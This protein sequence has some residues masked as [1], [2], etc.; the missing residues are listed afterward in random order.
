MELAPAALRPYVGGSS[1][2]SALDLVLGY[3]GL[4]RVFGSG[5]PGRGGGASFSGTPGLFRLFNAEMGG[6]AAWL[7]PLSLV[8]LVTGLVARRRTPRDDLARA[9]YLMWGLW[10]VTHVLLFSFMSGTIHGYYTVVLAPAI[11]ALVGGGV[12]EL[13]RAR[14]R[15]PWAG[16]VLGAAV[17][18]SVA[19][20]WTLLDRTPDFFPGLGTAVFAVGVAV[21]AAL[22][23]PATVLPRRVSLVA[24]GLA[25]AV[26]LAGPAAYA[27]DTMATA[28]SGGAVSAGPAADDI[29]RG[30]GP[31]A[32]GFRAPGSRQPPPGDAPGFASPGGASVPSFWG[33][34]GMG[35]S[36]DS[37]TIDF[38]VANRGAAIW[39]VAVRSANSAAP[40]ELATGLPVMAMGGFTGSDPTPTLEQL[41]AY[42]ASGQLRFVL[43][44]GGAGPGSGSDVSSWVTSACTAV[45]ATTSTGLYDCAGGAD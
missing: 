43:V 12:V 18:V 10:L 40:I 17:T 14:D 16:A 38:L 8:G 36:L 11:G 22:A 29:G 45:T 33:R 37:A 15:V 7:L 26:L 31:G 24:M 39:I 1:D 20:A 13:W 35:G 41:Q 21:G 44:G 28:Y 5:G 3:D 6:Q 42:V 2:G 25:L 23:L 34:G 9:A 32:G 27:V 30:G 4:G 19:L